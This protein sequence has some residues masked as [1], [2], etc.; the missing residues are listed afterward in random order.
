[1]KIIDLI[2]YSKEQKTIESGNRINFVLELG[3]VNTVV[4]N[5]VSD[6]DK[7][8]AL[9]KIGLVRCIEY[10]KEKYFEKN[11]TTILNDELKELVL[12]HANEK[13]LRLK[14]EFI[15]TETGKMMAGPL[16]DQLLNYLKSDENNFYNFH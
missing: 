15:T 5:I 1:M 6:A 10:T 3:W 9:G 12:K 7:L 4:R 11:K 13:L 16:H 8:E 2:S 14:D